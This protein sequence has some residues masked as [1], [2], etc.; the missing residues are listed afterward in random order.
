MLSPKWLREIDMNAV[1][2]VAVSEKNNSECGHAFSKVAVT[3]KVNV[4]TKVADTAKKRMLLL[5]L[6]SLK[7]K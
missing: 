2:K 5:K 6:L 7:N 1:T 4:V 3:E